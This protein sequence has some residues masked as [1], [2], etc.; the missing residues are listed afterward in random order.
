MAKSKKQKEL[1]EELLRECVGYAGWHD[2]PDGAYIKHDSMF[3]NMNKIKRLIEMGA[4]VN[5]KDSEGRSPLHWSAF[6]N[7]VALGELL[8][9]AGAKVNAKDNKGRSPLYWATLW[10]Y[11]EIE[12]LLKQHGAEE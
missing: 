12:D 2:K 8:I 4:D 3:F 1:D 6:R 11:K 7:T 5:A 9:S 10:G